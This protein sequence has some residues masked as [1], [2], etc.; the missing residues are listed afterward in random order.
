MDKETSRQHIDEAT[1]RI[2]F[3]DLEKAS[4][5]TF[6]DRLIENGTLS[7]TQARARI[8]AWMQTSPKDQAKRKFIPTVLD[9][10]Q[11]PAA[12]IA[13]AK[14]AVFANEK[15][16]RNKAID[17]LKRRPGADYTAVL[18]EGLRY[19]WAAIAN[20]AAEA[21]V[22]LNRRDLVGRLAEFLKEPDP[23]APFDKNLRGKNVTVVREL[24]RLN[25]RQNCI[26][27]HAPAT[28]DLAFKESGSSSEFL[29][30]VVP[31]RPDDSFSVGYSNSLQFPDLAVRADVTYLR[32]DFSLLQKGR[33]D[34]EPE[35]YDFLVRTREL[36]DHEFILYRDWLRNQPPQASP[37]HQAALWAL[38]QLIA[39]TPLA[40]P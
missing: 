23:R 13:L 39:K 37:N 40:Y 10:M 16:I 5:G 15:D 27:C 34:K 1:D 22:K 21:I 8:A 19:P 6:K 11:Q 31:T 29:A 4:D 7:D 35:R 12:T 25:H 32:Q 9:A 24:V 33:D 28:S 20:Q 14:L 2:G 36:R 3:D 26:L 18:F 17:A 30:A 38:R